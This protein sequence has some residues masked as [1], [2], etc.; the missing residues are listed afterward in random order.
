ME[1]RTWN[2]LQQSAAS[3]L[4]HALAKH[5]QQ[6]SPDLSSPWHPRDGGHPRLAVDTLL[7]CLP[8]CSPGELLHP[9]YCQNGLYAA[10]AHVLLP[11]YALC[12]WREPLHHYYAQNPQHFLVPWQGDR[13]WSLS[14]TSVSHSF[15]VQHGLGV[16][17]G[18]G[19]GQVRGRLQSPET[20]HHPEPPSHQDLGAGCCLPRSSAFQSSTLH[21]SGASLLQNEYHPSHVLWVYGSDQAGLCRDQDLQ[22]LQPNCCL[23]YRRFRFHINPLFVCSHPSHCLPSSVQGC[24]AQDLGHVWIPRLCDLSSLYASLLLLP[25]PQ[26]WAPRASSRSHLCG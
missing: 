4:H 8:K 15:A 18:H 21:A 11:L 9:V 24:S 5:Y 25:H 26:V 20:L 12:G 23:P 2:H 14:H 22:N 10:R 19:R 7:P 16:H 1:K 17:P 3:L 13:F 6:P